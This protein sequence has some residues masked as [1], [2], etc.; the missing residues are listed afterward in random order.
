MPQGI[1]CNLYIPCTCACACL[2]VYVHTN[3][4]AKKSFK[5]NLD[6]Q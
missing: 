5:G 1:C 3:V 4:F 2:Y 6:I